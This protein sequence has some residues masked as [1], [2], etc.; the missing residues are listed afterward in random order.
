MAPKKSSD[1]KSVERSAR[2]TGTKKSSKDRSQSRGKAFLN[3]LRGK[4]EEAKEEVKDTKDEPK[5]A[6]E[7]AAV[8]DA[9]GKCR[10]LPMF[11]AKLTP[12]AATEEAEVP[13][14]TEAA[15]APVAEEA[16]TEETK[17]EM[18][19]NRRSSRFLDYVKGVRSPTTEK[20]QE[21]VIPAATEASPE[22]PAPVDAAVAPLPLT[23][24]IVAADTTEAA[25]ATNGETKAEPA[26]PTAEKADRR[27]SSFFNTLTGTLKKAEKKTEDKMNPKKSTE[28][29]APKDEVKAAEPEADAAPAPA[30]EPKS[31]SE[32]P[33][34]EKKEN[35]LIGLIRNS[36]KAIRGNKEPRKAKAPEKVEES[37]AEASDA[38]AAE[39]APEVPTKETE[40]VKPAETEP[41]APT[42]PTSI[43]D[44]V[45]EAVNVGSAP[46]ANP[47]VQAT[48]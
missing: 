43:G 28:V 46:P 44:V 47:T 12:S 40:A 19:K 25:A 32:T 5:E 11:W 41:A 45:P 35:K 48:A 9:P 38:K 10:H 4:K 1:S 18:P 24:P 8:A 3:T 29:E 21:E 37:A 7:A 31:D 42:G 33:V 22:I 27:R 30:V 15:S 13:P 20:K 39:T 17:P 34:K 23:E 16:K 2:E 36:S 26:S 6:G 14:V